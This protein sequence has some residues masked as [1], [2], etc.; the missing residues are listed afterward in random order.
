LDC[1]PFDTQTNCTDPLDDPNQELT[2]LLHAILLKDEYKIRF[3]LPAVLDLHS[4][5]ITKQLDR[6]NSQQLVLGTQQ[7]ENL[8]AKAFDDAILDYCRKEY[9]AEFSATS[10]REVPHLIEMATQLVIERVCARAD[11]ALKELLKKYIIQ[12][13][14]GKATKRAISEQFSLGLRN[15]LRKGLVVETGNKTGLYK[16][17]NEQRLAELITK[18]IS[19]MSNQTKH[20]Q[21]KRKKRLQYSI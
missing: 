20:Q 12:S 8:T 9:I 1:S 13:N 21:G 3:K 7:H 14:T 5:D 10:Y 15:L 17:V 11:L 16:V 4:E 19:D 6:E 2:H 18:I